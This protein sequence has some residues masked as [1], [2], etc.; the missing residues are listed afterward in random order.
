LEKATLT[1]ARFYR[2][3]D[4]WLLGDNSKSE[5]TI[6]FEESTGR[7]VFVTGVF[8]AFSHGEGQR[9]PGPYQ[10]GSSIVLIECEGFKP[11]Q[12]RFYDEM[13]DV[14][15]TLSFAAEKPSN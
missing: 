6:R 11:L 5:E 12:A 1:L 7:F 9:E 14:R 15:I 8:A 10:T 2:I 3:N 4:S 13:P